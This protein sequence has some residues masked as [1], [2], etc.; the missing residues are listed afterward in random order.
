MLACSPLRS[1]TD[2]CNHTHTWHIPTHN[3]DPQA[4][5]ASALLHRQSTVTLVHL[6][7]TSIILSFRHTH[8]HTISSF[9]PLQSPTYQYVP[10]TVHIPHLRHLPATH[11]NPLLDA[12]APRPT[13]SRK[14]PRTPS[15]LD[16]PHGSTAFAATIPTVV[17][18]GCSHSHLMDGGSLGQRGKYGKQL[19]GY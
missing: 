10:Q 5:L 19:E 18:Q 2:S 12:H 3:S 16:R 1:G 4:Q 15:D 8:I 6:K 11:P 14:A 7:L 17:V 13:Q 9:H